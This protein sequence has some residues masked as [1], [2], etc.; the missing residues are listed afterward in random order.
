MEILK[1]RILEICTRLPRNESVVSHAASK[2]DRQY[3]CNA[4]LRRVHKITVA[5]EKH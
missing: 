3:T 1:K 2:E 5:V 4:T